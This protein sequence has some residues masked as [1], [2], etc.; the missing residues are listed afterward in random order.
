ML[1]Y[2]LIRGC[3]VERR[4]EPVNSK[5]GSRHIRAFGGEEVDSLV[6]I[7]TCQIFISWDFL[8]QQLPKIYFHDQC[9]QGINHWNL[10]LRLTLHTALWFASRAAFDAELLF[11]DVCICNCPWGVKNGQSKKGFSRDYR[12]EKGG[13]QRRGKLPSG[14]GRM[15]VGNLN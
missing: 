5:F 13:G 10:L 4:L 7:V 6:P 8:S 14:K 2:S 15:K 12:H 9:A 11:A 3:I 1:T